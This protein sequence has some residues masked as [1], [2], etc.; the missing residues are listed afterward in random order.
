MLLPTSWV[1]RPPVPFKSV[2][3]LPEHKWLAQSGRATRKRGSPDSSGTSA[4]P[5]QSSAGTGPRAALLPRERDCPLPSSYPALTPS[6]LHS[7]AHISGAPPV[8]RIFELRC[9]SQPQ[10]AQRRLGV[11]ALQRLLALPSP[12][13][14]RN[15]LSGSGSCAGRSHFKRAGPDEE[16][17]QG[18][19]EARA[20][21]YGW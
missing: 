6:L 20:D 5:T 8:D 14:R 2:L 11:H 10:P 18:V 16:H 7:T 4:S 15:A 1:P 17:G 3:V 13:R 21:P 12:A 19:D 9:Q